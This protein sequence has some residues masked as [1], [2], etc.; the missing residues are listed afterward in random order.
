MP[1]LY[2]LS[3]NQLWQLSSA[4]RTESLEKGKV[5]FKKGDAGDSFYIIKDGIFSCCDGE[6]VMATGW[7]F[8]TIKPSCPLSMQSERGRELARIGEGSCFGEL[9]LLRQETRAAT[10]VALSDSQVSL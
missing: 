1:I 7:D 6:W 2:S 5:V 3:E 8:T 10:V 4:M 9:A